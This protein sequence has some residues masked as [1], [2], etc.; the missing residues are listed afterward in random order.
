MTVIIGYNLIPS[1]CVAQHQEAGLASM[2]IAIVH[3]VGDLE[4]TRNL[5]TTTKE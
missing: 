4:I 3:R 1:D 2:C 5:E